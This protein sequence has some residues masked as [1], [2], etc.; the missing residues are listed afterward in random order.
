M[1]YNLIDL[2]VTIYAE[3]EELEQL[4]IVARNPY[5]TTHIITFTLQVIRNICNFEEGMKSWHTRT[6]IERL[7]NISR[8]TFNINT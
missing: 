6:I 5:S 3:V 7:G 2:L 8:I 4:G 1:Q